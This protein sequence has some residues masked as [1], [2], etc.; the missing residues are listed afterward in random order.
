VNYN[1]H[2]SSLPNAG[3]PAA[4]GFSLGEMH[5]VPLVQQIAERLRA[6]IL[7]GT[8][9]A[10]TPLHQEKVAS[11]LGVSRTPLREAFRILEQD[12]LVR[13][14]SRTGTVEVIQLTLQ[15]AAQLYQLR[16][17]IDALAARLAAGQP[18]SPGLER[19]LRQYAERMTHAVQ[20]F[21]TRE[22]LSAHTAFHLGVVQASG[23]T[24]MGQLDHVIRISSH[25]LHPVLRTKAE[26]MAA[27]ASEHM[28]ILNAIVAGQSELAEQLAREH[29]DR[30][31]SFW[32][33]GQQ[34]VL[35]API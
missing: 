32:V 18:L 25:M 19:E 13:V 17:V 5:R 8:I 31:R 6:L 16:E 34:G 12:G 15:D 35:N 4:V 23:N 28:A 21:D 11:E 10:G 27:S 26:R 22:F 9:P 20:P 33:A 2:Q 3:Q 30:A 1:D 24:W 14:S 29:I 7:D